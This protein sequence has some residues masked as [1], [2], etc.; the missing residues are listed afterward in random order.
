[1][2]SDLH[3][4]TIYSDSTLTPSE[5]VTC[6]KNAGISCISITDHETMEGIPPVQAIASDLVVIAGVGRYE[7]EPV[8][9]PVAAGVVNFHPAL[10][11]GSVPEAEYPYYAGILMA[12]DKLVDAGEGGDHFSVPGAAGGNVSKLHPARG[13]LVK[14]GGGGGNRGNLGPRLRGTG[15]GIQGTEYGA[16]LRESGAGEDEH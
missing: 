1:M 10:G 3:I 11:S 16:G 7:G 2:K 12:V 13:R 9:H 5:V 8:L 4:H 15:G 14:D 6:A